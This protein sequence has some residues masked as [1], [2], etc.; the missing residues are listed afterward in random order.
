MLSLRELERAF[1]AWILHGTESPDLADLVAP[2]GW[3]VEER[4]AIHRNNVFVS[5]TK[6]LAATFPVV[7]R[8]VDER[9]FAY[10]AHEFLIARPPAEACL[11][12]Y[13]GE[14]AD[15]LASFPPCRDLA[16][17]A[18]VARLEW[19]MQRAAHAEEAPSLS[20]AALAPFAAD[21]APRLLFTLDPSIGYVRSRFP[22]DRI[23]A[24]NRSC[25]G[26][27]EIVDLDAGGAALEVRRIAEDVIYR[28]L[29]PAGFAFRAALREDA[30]LESAAEA[31]LAADASFDLGQALPLLFTEGAVAS[32]SLAPVA[33]SGG[34]HERA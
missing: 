12:A 7:S 11:A 2:D 25:D 24:V 31:A 26:S 22:I 3:P 8:L 27:D 6:A 15:F 10:A 33:T 28:S 23:W 30:T 32:I 29:D 4:L 20:P 1:G 18:D 19:L 9:F 17:L 13:G 14:F 34:H 16:Y 5:L 21:E